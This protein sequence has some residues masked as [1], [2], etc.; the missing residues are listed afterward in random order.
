MVV[1]PSGS[2]DTYP[3]EPLT[4]AQLR[5]LTQISRRIMRTINSDERYLD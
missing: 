4:S 2:C 1:S 3:G 5:Q